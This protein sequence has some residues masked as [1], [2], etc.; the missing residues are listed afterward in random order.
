VPF[1][2]LIEIE[3]GPAS[4]ISEDPADRR[5]ADAAYADQ[6]DPQLRLLTA[7]PAIR[8]CVCGAGDIGEGQTARIAVATPRSSGARCLGGSQWVLTHYNHKRYVHNVH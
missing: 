2:L 3:E 6:A 1:D 7:T 5:G 4:P 8:G